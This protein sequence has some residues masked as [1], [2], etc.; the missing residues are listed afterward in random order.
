MIYYVYMIVLQII[1]VPFIEV[2]KAIVWW[3]GAGLRW[4]NRWL[5]MEVRFVE[6][7]EHLGQWAQ[8]LFTPMY[9]D[10][11]WQGRFIS[12]FV[13][14]IVLSYRLLWTVIWSLMHVMMWLSYLL[15]PALAVFMLVKRLLM[16]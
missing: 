4:M 11:S 8:N 15:L 6:H 3:Y 10:A 2:F 12:I 13:R 5:V 7:R 16:L 9:G 14:L 1:V